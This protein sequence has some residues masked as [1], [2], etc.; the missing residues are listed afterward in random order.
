MDRNDPLLNWYG[1]KFLKIVNKLRDDKEADK[2]NGYRDFRIPSDDAFIDILILREKTP[3]T[4]QA[5]IAEKAVKAFIKEFDEFE[6]SEGNSYR[7]DDDGI[8]ELWNV[9]IEKKGD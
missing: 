6:V 9:L 4:P 1:G 3:N 5:Y 2:L 8:Y 7:L